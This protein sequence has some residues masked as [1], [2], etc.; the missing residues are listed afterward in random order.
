MP[1][2]IMHFCSIIFSIRD[3][4]ISVGGG[5]KLREGGLVPQKYF[6]NKLLM[7]KTPQRV[8]D[9]FRGLRGRGVLK[10]NYIMCNRRS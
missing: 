9:L 6:L 2:I 1:H 5:T 7:G 3:Q 4:K 10:P 8:T